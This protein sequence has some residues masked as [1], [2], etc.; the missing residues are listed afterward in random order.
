MSFRASVRLL[1]VSAL[2]LG[3]VPALAGTTDAGSLEARVDRLLWQLM[4]D[5][6][7]SNVPIAAHYERLRAALIDEA[8]FSAA[9]PC[10]ALDRV[11]HQGRTIT[12]EVRPEQVEAIEQLLFTPPSAHVVANEAPAHLMISSAD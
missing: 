5:E 2:V 12:T 9:A 10:V 4:N 7:Y 1:L 6:R 8:C 11:T 3:A